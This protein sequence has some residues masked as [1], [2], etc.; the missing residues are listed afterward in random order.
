MTDRKKKAHKLSWEILG[1][2]GISMLIALVLLLF[3]RLCAT[4]VVE[5]V[6]YSRDMV[7]RE[8]QWAELDTRIFQGSLVLAVAFFAL[9]F[10]ALLG[11]RLAYIRTITRGI[12]TLQ[13]GALGYTLPLEGNNELTQ[14]AEAVNYLSLTQQQVQ[15]KEQLLQQEKEQLIRS[16]SHDIRTPLTS[17]LAYAEYLQTRPDLAEE[18]RKDHLLLIR[19]KAEQIK[20]L[21]DVLLSGGVRNPEYFPD[22]KL[23]MQ[24]LAEEF[25]EMLDEKF[26]LRVDMDAC[27][28]FGG[29]FDVGEMRRIFDNLASNVAKYADPAKTVALQISLEEAGLV[30]RQS[31]AVAAPRQT[32]ES[33][34]VGLKSIRRIA[35]SYGGH[36]T[37]R[38]ENSAFFITVVLAQI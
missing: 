23:L 19:K 8:S 26:E 17:I 11:E 9:L 22:G 28:A 2:L 20:E 3:L 6:A 10:L 21:T 15:E 5:S 29:S 37:T 4:A 18:A 34:G 24:Q 13:S 31:N 14:L 35:Q 36:V 1:L 16:L 38:E 30:I 7:L 32:E 12:D 27:P 33:Y 25:A